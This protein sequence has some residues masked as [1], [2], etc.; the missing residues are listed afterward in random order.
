MVSIK[1]IALVLV[2]ALL[3]GGMAY[4]AI[5]AI[6]GAFEIGKVVGSNI[7]TYPLP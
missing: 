7:T 3:V 1:T 4:M 2:A 5:M 6:S